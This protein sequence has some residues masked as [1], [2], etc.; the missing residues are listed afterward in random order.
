M[1]RLTCSKGDAALPAQ[2]VPDVIDWSYTV[3]RLH[4]TQKPIKVLRPLVEAFCPEGGSVLDPFCGS[5]STLIA[6][7]QLGRDALG[8]ELDA[9]HA[10]TASLRLASNQRHVAKSA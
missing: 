1:S 3:N 10:E 5:G 4:P 6:A 9:D 7:E 2:P 8:I